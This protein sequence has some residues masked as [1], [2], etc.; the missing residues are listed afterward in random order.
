MPPTFDELAELLPVSRERIFPVPLLVGAISDTHVNPGGGRRIAPEVF[1]LFE[2]FE[3]GLILHAGDA[4]CE[5]VLGRLARIAPLIAVPGNNENPFLQRALPNEVEL[6]IG[7]HRVGLIHG[8]QGTSARATAQAVFGG[9]VDF[10]VYGHSHI[11]KIERIGETTYFNPGSA[12]DRRWGEY[13]GVG[14]IRFTTEKIDP[15]LV[16]FKSPEHLENV[17]P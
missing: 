12:T 4:N 15:E 8:H 14:L 13:Y 10:C 3:V 11:P 1:D 2:R 9:R 17:A 16:L 5:D 7:S 6:T